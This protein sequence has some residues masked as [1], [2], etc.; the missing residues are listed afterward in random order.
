MS[1][2]KVMAVAI[3]GAA[4]LY[5][6]TRTPAGAPAQGGAGQGGSLGA[7]GAQLGAA[8]ATIPGVGPFLGAGAAV[9]G[10][11]MDVY[12]QLGPAQK[13]QLAAAGKNL[14]H[15]W[16][17]YTPTGLVA[18]AFGVE[19]SRDRSRARRAG[20]QG[21]LSMSV[22]EREGVEQ[23]A[24]A[25]FL[26]LARPDVQRWEIDQTGTLHVQYEGRQGPW[27]MP[28]PQRAINPGGWI[29]ELTSRLF[30]SFVQAG[31]GPLPA[32]YFPTFD[33]VGF[34]PENPYAP[35]GWQMPEA[36]AWEAELR[37]RL[38]RR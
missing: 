32:D 3:G 13:Q 29:A 34:V 14:Q 1:P 5:L 23:H 2:L 38:A 21:Q 26:A 6:V 7:L 35:R 25:M 19:S 27:R 18:K 30:G 17:N 20:L 31:L 8:L 24:S 36:D 10:A 11:G 4:L 12:G 37:A 9:G 33:S 22:H 15:N 16:L 28:L